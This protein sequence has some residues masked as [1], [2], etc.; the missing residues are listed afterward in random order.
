MKTLIASTV[1]F[2]GLLQSVAGQDKVSAAQLLMHLSGTWKALR[3]ETPRVTALDE[4]VFGAGANEVRDVTLV[5]HAAG[6]GDLQVQTKVVGRNGRVYAPSQMDVKFRV[7]E[8]IALA[9]S[10]IVPTVTVVSAEDRFLDGSHERFTR[11]GARLSIHLVSLTSSQ[12]NIQFDTPDGRGGFG[13]T[14]TRRP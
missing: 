11:D 12:I 14:L 4:Q 6:D 1:V 3:Q 9:P 8:P 5:V 10:R 13:T 2:F 7:G